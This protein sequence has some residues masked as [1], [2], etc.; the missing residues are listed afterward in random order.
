M[1]FARDVRGVTKK[2]VSFFTIGR[3]GRKCNGENG[4]GG[5]R[6]HDTREG[7]PVFEANATKAESFVESRN[8]G[9]SLTASAVRESKLK[10]FFR[11]ALTQ[12]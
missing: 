1:R 6:T 2:Q 9:L 4:Q 3:T 8:A 5:I 7:I 10:R 11:P 12:A